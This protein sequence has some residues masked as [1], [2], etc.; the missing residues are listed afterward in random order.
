MALSYTESHTDF[1]VEF[2]S[3]C[4]SSFI[5][6]RQFFAQ[7]DVLKVLN[8][9]KRSAKA[10]STVQCGR[11]VQ[12]NVELHYTASASSH[13]KATVVPTEPGCR[14]SQPFVRAKHC[15]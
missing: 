1:L 14:S 6:T 8:K 11:G 12:D 5:M 9:A 2:R 15:L 10:C 13:H 4:F 3:G 7:G